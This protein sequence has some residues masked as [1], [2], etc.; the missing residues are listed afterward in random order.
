MLDILR[1]KLAADID[2]GTL[3]KH[4]RIDA[5]RELLKLDARIRAIDAREADA[6]EGTDDDDEDGA[7]EAW[8][9]NAL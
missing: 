1:S 6:E 7:G 2:E 3:P 9:P 4:S 8:D 5:I